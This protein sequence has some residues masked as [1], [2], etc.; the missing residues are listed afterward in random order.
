MCI[1]A[2]NAVTHSYLATPTSSVALMDLAFPCAGNLDDGVFDLGLED[3][4]E[5]GNFHR[6]RNQDEAPKFESSNPMKPQPEA[7]VSSPDALDLALMA[8]TAA[9]EENGGSGAQQS[10]VISPRSP[11]C[12]APIRQHDDA[13][14][15]SYTQSRP[16]MGPVKP[17]MSPPRVQQGFIPLPKRSFDRTFSFGGRSNVGASS[18]SSR[19]E[20][21]APLAKTKRG[22]YSAT[23]SY[24]DFFSPGLRSGD[25]EGFSPVHLPSSGMLLPSDRRSE[26]SKPIPRHLQDRSRGDANATQRRDGERGSCDPILL[27][28]PNDE[29]ALAEI[30]R[31]AAAYVYTRATQKGMDCITGAED[32]KRG[33]F[34]VDVARGAGM[35][36]S[37]AGDVEE[38]EWE[39]E[40]D[41]GTVHDQGKDDDLLA[42]ASELHLSVAG[43]LRSVNELLKRKSYF[44]IDTSWSARQ[45]PCPPTAWKGSCVG[46]K[47]G[48]GGGVGI[49]TNS[50]GDASTSNTVRPRPNVSSCVNIV[51]KIEGRWLVS[52]SKKPRVGIFS[53]PGEKVGVVQKYVAT[54]STWRQPCVVRHYVLCHQ[55][56]P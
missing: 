30:D 23:V 51:T 55:L 45:L 44:Y 10:S 4:D 34:A 9:S 5:A 37:G 3:D 43:Q 16:E 20:N 33:S 28:P 24:G 29:E 48:D 27:G 53:I 2:L 39:E 38:E 1:D 22:G 42:R 47:T 8:F 41:A 21:S 31:A 25:S 50:G 19:D 35:S 15:G 49:D 11:F 26:V 36:S 52:G 7:E 32:S 46:T 17:A 14:R 18:N 54:T 56:S 13:A 40:L 6:R 12:G